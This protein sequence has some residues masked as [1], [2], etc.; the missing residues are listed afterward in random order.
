MGY[1]ITRRQ[2]TFWDLRCDDGRIE[3]VHFLGKEEFAFLDPIASSYAIV[4]EHAL[5][6]DYQFAWEAI[7]VASPVSAPDQVLRAL[8]LAIDARLDG[9]RPA[10]CYLNEFGAER[11]L[12]DGYG[13]LLAAPTPI[14]ETCRAAL[15]AA[16]ARFSTL[17]GR[18]SR[19]PR[20]AL[21]A[22]VNSVVAKSFRVEVVT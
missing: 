12:R 1:E 19:W 8:T 14:A 7:Y 9:W 3:R 11:V 18:P 6:I 22:G 20:Q 10:S 4:E 17:P 2:T 15:N 16:G 13:Q 21:I 5:L